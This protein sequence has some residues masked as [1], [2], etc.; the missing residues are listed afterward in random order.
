MPLCHSILI[1]IASLSRLSVCRIVSDALALLCYNIFLS[2]NCSFWRVSRERMY[3]FPLSLERVFLLF[4]CLF[5]VRVR[6]LVFLKRTSLAILKV[7]LRDRQC[8]RVS[9]IWIGVDEAFRAETRPPTY[10]NIW[11]VFESTP[12]TIR[13]NNTFSS[14]ASCPPV[15]D[16]MNSKHILCTAFSEDSILLDPKANPSWHFIV[17]LVLSLLAYRKSL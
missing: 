9:L 10:F 14:R 6:C 17:E 5:W 8:Q 4:C 13:D 7:F 2:G 11:N 12:T 16:P 15:S 3:P 1:F